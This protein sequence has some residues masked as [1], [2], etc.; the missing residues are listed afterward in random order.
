MYCLCLR[1]VRFSRTR[2]RTRIIP[3]LCGPTAW[4]PT[5]CFNVISVHYF[6]KIKSKLHGVLNS[7]SISLVSEVLLFQ[8]CPYGIVSEHDQ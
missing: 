6:H 8:T 5:K 7:D 4:M 3:D 2:I 1:L